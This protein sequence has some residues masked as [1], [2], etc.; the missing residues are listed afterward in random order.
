M[1]MDIYGINPRTQEGKPTEPVENATSE[2]KDEYFKS[3][4]EWNN[5][6]GQY[7]RASIWSWVAILSICEMSIEI[8]KLPLNTKGWGNNEGDGLK[9]QEDCEI[10]ASAIEAFFMLNK[11]MKDNDDSIHIVTQLWTDS[12]GKFL[13]ITTSKKLTDTYKLGQILYNKVVL[14]DGTIARPCCYANKYHVL[15]FVKFLRSCGGFKIC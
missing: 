9:T 6:S 2:E 11:N 4:M 12:F 14:E 1:G 13:P 5:S 3:L 10:L 8:F 7:F 15:N